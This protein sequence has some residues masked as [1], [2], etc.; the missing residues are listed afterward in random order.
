MKNDS[1]EIEPFAFQRSMDG[2]EDGREFAQFRNKE[3]KSKSVCPGQI[4]GS[5]R[6][7]YF[8][9]ER[10]LYS[11]IFDDSESASARTTNSQMRTNHVRTKKKNS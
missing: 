4:F 2:G 8:H 6:S 3:G 1:N 7:W 10:N 5:I 9:I 11:M